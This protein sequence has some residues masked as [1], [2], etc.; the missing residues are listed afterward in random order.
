MQEK[1]YIMGQKAKRLGQVLNLV[2]L[3]IYAISR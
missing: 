2:L 1:I 3:V